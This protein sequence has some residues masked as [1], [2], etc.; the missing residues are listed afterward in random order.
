VS[1]IPEGSDG[2]RC[3]PSRYGFQTGYGPR[4]TA[5][6]CISGPQSPEQVPEEVREIF[7]SNRSKIKLVAVVYEGVNGDDKIDIWNAIE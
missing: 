5:N 2:C 3:Y 4:L 1:E 6:I 7:A